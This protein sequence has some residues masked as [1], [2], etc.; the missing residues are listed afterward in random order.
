[1]DKMTEEKSQFLG[2]VHRGDILHNFGGIFHTH[3]HK[4]QCIETSFILTGWEFRCDRIS[5]VSIE[6][7]LLKGQRLD[8]GLRTRAGMKKKYIFFSG[9]WD[10]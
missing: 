7:A 4:M 10:K 6:E 8:L 2:I 9:S 3:T 5:Y 1:M